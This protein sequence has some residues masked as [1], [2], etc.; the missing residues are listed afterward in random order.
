MNRTIK[1]N[2]FYSP[3]CLPSI[4]S[5]FLLDGRNLNFIFHY[6]SQ[7]QFDIPLI[8][9][10]SCCTENNVACVSSVTP[11]FQLQPVRLT[12]QYYSDDGK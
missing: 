10:P 12:V 3:F 9:D 2:I 4:F 11:N 7:N 5:N 8:D 1:I 6:V